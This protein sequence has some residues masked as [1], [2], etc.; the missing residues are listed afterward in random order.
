MARS[1]GGRKERI[2]S[3]ISAGRERK[4]CL[5]SL[6]AMDSVRASSASSLQEVGGLQHMQEEHELQ[7]PDEIGYGTYAQRSSGG[8]QVKPL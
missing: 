5:L 1:R 6:G 7:Q 2:W 8:H 4:L 3:I